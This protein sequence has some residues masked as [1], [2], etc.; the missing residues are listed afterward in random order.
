M[1]IY[2]LR[3]FIYINLMNIIFSHLVILF[4]LLFNQFEIVLI[5]SIQYNRLNLA[6]EVSQPLPLSL[7]LLVIIYPTQLRRNPC[8]DMRNG[9]KIDT[10]G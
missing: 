3:I 2:L 10:L 7:L 8:G 4:N 9:R 1:F 6:I 5:N